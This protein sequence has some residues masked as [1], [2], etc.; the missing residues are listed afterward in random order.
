MKS[1]HLNIFVVKKFWAGPSSGRYSYCHL[2]LV[3]PHALPG[4]LQNRML[5]TWKPID[6]W[7]SLSRF[8]SN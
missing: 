8:I 1:S 7:K 2:K 3:R 6:Q 4:F 5:T